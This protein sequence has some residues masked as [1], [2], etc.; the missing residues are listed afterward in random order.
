MVI[1]SSRLIAHG[2]ACQAAGQIQRANLGQK[3][4]QG[5][6]ISA[7]AEADEGVAH[8]RVLAPGC[9][10]DDHCALVPMAIQQGR[11]LI[12]RELLH[13]AIVVPE[14]T[15][16]LLLRLLCCAGHYIARVQ[17]ALLASG[18]FPPP[19]ALPLVLIGEHWPC[20]GLAAYGHVSACMQLIG[21]HALQLR[22]ACLHNISG[23]Q[24]PA[25][26]RLLRVL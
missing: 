25:I 5:G 6:G 2:N 21:W 15:H 7:V 22:Y 3:S 13:I 11:Q 24:M 16:G 4:Q 18:I 26:L 8:L 20:A 10:H 17:P 12:M 23:I 1:T 9:I 19:P 14:I